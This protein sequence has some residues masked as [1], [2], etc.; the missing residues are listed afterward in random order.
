M[1]VL[2]PVIVWFREDLRL[3]DNPALTAAADTG[4]PIVCLYIRETGI[5][6]AR[7][8]GGASRW[9]LNQSLKALAA[10]LEGLGG[11]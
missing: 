9:W 6:F 11:S 4:A 10:S 7:A 8:P 5:P 1:S 3:T 2:P